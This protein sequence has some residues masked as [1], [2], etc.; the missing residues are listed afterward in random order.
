MVDLWCAASAHGMTGRLGDVERSCCKGKMPWEEREGTEGTAWGTWM[1]RYH[2]CQRRD[3][4]KQ[5]EA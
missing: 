2:P 4:E 5:A 3:R 1:D